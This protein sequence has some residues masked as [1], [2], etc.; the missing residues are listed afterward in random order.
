MSYFCYCKK[1]GTFGIPKKNLRDAGRN[2]SKPQNRDC[3]GRTRKNRIPTLVVIDGHYLETNDPSVA[4]GPLTHIS[5][6]T[7]KVFSIQQHYVWPT[8]CI[9]SLRMNLQEQTANVALYSIK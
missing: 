7:Y 3:P 5:Y 2:L 6:S 4:P 1:S 9:Y 8:Q